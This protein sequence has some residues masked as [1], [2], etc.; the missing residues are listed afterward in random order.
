MTAIFH[1]VE[2]NTEEWEALRIGKVTSS[3]MSIVM[4]NFGKSFGDP[5]KRYA[6]K[7]ALERITGQKAEHSFSNEH[8]ERGHIQEP[9]ARLE[10]ESQMFCTVSNGGFFENGN[11][12]ASPDGLVN[13]DGLIEIKSVIAQVHYETLMRK[14][15]DPSY[16]WQLYANLKTTNRTWID[17]VSYCSDFPPE[18]QLIIHRV[19]AS[20]CE[21]QFA[22]I[23]TRLAE[24]EKLIESTIKTI[25]G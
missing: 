6:L 4:A 19:L 18:K 2:Q 17:F 25:K 7:L 5:A 24:F 12:G 3:S 11:Y 21:E 10:Y 16:K 8:T 23:D 20:E 14:S 15:F 9:I 22:M 1:D 13:Y